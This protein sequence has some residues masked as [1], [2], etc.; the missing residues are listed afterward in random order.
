VSETTEKKVMTL[1][2]CAEYDYKTNARGRLTGW[3][4]ICKDRQERGISRKQR[5]LLKRQQAA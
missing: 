4:K 1:S 2:E 5:R 3:G